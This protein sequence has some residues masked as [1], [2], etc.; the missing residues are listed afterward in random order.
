MLKMLNILS[1]ILKLLTIITCIKFNADIY[2]YENQIKL[3]KTNQI[4]FI[5]L[6]KILNLNIWLIL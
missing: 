6:L 3:N 5:K 2:K 1:I 4:Y